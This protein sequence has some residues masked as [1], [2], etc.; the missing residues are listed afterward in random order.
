M[1]E[2]RDCY[3]S[4]RAL[5]EREREGTDYVI[6]TWP[7]RTDTTVM[8]PHGGEIEPGTSEIGYAIAGNEHGFYAFEG[9]KPSLNRVLHLTSTRFDEPRALA[10]ARRSRLV[11][12]IH[13]CGEA[14]EVVYVGSRCTPL[15][16]HTTTILRQWGFAVDAHQRLRG[17]HPDNLCNLGREGKGIQ[18][19]LTSGLRRTLFQDLTPRGRRHPTRRFGAFVDAMRTVLVRTRE[20]PPGLPDDGGSIA[21]KG[22]P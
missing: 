14:R 13:G 10:L 16:E 11:V 22:H 19:E 12:T 9:R 4:Y 20:A 18:L 8:A 7:G 15:L 2:P 21:W 3:G 5:Q 6:V 1:P 17:R